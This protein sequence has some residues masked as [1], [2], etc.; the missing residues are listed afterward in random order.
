MSQ[1]QSKGWNIALWIVQVL[2]ALAFASAGFMKLTSPIESLQAAGMGWVNDFPAFMVR[3]V[4]ISELAGGVGLILPAA[5]RIKPVLTPVAGF[6]LALVMV[7]ALG[8]HV[9]KGEFQALP[10]NIVLGGLSAL[11]GWGPIAAKS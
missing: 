10:I 5:L 11:I 9:M 7:L 8:Y 3:F 4:G 6:A 1:S 2:M